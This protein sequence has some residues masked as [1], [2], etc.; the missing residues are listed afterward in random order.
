MKKNIK[1][2]L[3]FIIPIVILFTAFLI[4]QNVVNYKTQGGAKW[5]IGG[6]LELKTGGTFTLSGGTL[7]GDFMVTDGTGSFGAWGYDGEHVAITALTTNTNPGLGEYFMV[8]TLI[9]ANNVMAGEYARLLVMTTNQ[10][11]DV[12]MVGT[13]SQFRLRG[14]NIG[15][16]VHAGLWAYA[17][18][19]GTSVL[20]DAGTFD[21]ITATVESASTFTVGATEHITGITLDSS[22]NAGASGTID[23][24]TNFSAIYIKSNGLDWYYGMKITGVD[25]D[26]LGQNEETWTNSEDGFW[27]TG[28]GIKATG[29][30]TGQIARATLDED[31]LQIY[32]IPI[33]SLRAADLAGLTLAETAGDHYLV[34]GTNAITLSSEET[35]STTKTDVSYAQFILPPEYVAAGD[36]K[37]RI[38]HWV[39]GAG[40]S[41]AS[42][43]DFSVYE[44]DGN[45]AVGGDLID[46]EA[47]ATTEDTWTTTDF[48]VTATNL[49]AGDI[50]IIKFTSVVIENA[51]GSLF[52]KYDGLAVLLDIK[53]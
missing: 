21:A 51:A 36:V 2:K 4:A 3:K 47:T 50:L 53:G 35:T 20:S 5:V 34:L 44:Q 23:V 14:V 43:V 52:G 11:N 17:E 30:I 41:G 13:E 25:E 27:K 19:S 38:K 32:G 48:V 33:Y 1:G 22:I 24:G 42:T 7:V 40:T 15:K 18:Q 12:T 45:G 8:N 28:G 49:V 9:P 16:G 37:I 26:I 10:T 46:T 6:D 39:G 31:A 29:A